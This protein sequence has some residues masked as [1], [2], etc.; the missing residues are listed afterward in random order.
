ML[1]VL[2]IDPRIVFFVRNGQREDFLSG[3]IGETA[4]MQGSG[5][6]GKLLN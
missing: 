4:A 5:Q 6:H 1:G 2:P 3:Q